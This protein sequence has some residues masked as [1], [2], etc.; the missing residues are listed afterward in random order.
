MLFL[1]IACIPLP[2]QTRGESKRMLPGKRP[3][4]PR[5]PGKPGIVRDDR[6]VIFV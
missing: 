3:S 4:Q 6:F 1:S 2:P 5:V